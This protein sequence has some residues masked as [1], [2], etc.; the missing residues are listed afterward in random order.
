MELA[1]ILNKVPGISKV[2][3]VNYS[4]FIVYSLQIWDLASDIFFAVQTIPA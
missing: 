3:D 2:D 1:Y 4:A